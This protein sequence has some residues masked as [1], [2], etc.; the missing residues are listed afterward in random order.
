VIAGL[1]LEVSHNQSGVQILNKE[2]PIGVSRLRLDDTIGCG[3][4]LVSARYKKPSRHAGLTLVASPRLLHNYRYFRLHLDFV[5][6]SL[7]L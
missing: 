2:K 3:L 7:W 1:L 6:S 5:R 4:E